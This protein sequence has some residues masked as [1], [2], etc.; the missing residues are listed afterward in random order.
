MLQFRPFEENR[1][2]SYILQDDYADMPYELFTK[3]IEIPSVDVK[4]DAPSAACQLYIVPEQLKRRAALQ[5]KYKRRDKVGTI[6]IDLAETVRAADDDDLDDDFDDA[7]QMYYQKQPRSKYKYM[8]GTQDM[9]T[10]SIFQLSTADGSK[11]F[12]IEVPQFRNYLMYNLLA[13]RLLDTLKPNK[14]HLFVEETE[15]TAEKSTAQEKSTQMMAE[16][17]NGSYRGPCG[18]LGLSGVV[19]SF[20]NTA[21]L[22]NVV[23]VPVERSTDIVKTLYL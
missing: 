11:H 17:L 1:T 4:L 22:Q 3:E 19:A 23:F 13:V 20:L 16:F 12:L 2:P 10:I 14:V 21:T 9:R 18:E 5:K 15:R 8:Y 7:E 6:T